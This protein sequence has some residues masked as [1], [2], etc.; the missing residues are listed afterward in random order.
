M[1]GYSHCVF[2]TYSAHQQLLGTTYSPDH[3]HLGRPA[4][5]RDWE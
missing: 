1:S 3:E 2:E 4:V 5:L